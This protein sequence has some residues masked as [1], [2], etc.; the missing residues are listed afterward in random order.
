[1]ILLVIFVIYTKAL[2]SY[3]DLWV[4]LVLGSCYQRVTDAVDE[5]F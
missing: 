1:M 2:R 4:S 3:I 5:S